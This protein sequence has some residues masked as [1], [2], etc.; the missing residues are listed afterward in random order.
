MQI[1]RP[2]GRRGVGGRRTE[3]AGDGAVIARTLAAR[4]RKLMLESCV[5]PAR[6]DLG[7]SRAIDRVIVE[8]DR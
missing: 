3:Q 6:F 2:A 4:L 5:D 8:L 1:S 7:L